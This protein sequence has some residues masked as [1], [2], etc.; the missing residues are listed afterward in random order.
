VAVQSYLKAAGRPLWTARQ[1]SD[2][3]KT[4]GTPQG[5]DPTQRIGPLPDIRAALTAVGSD[6]PGPGAARRVGP[7]GWPIHRAYG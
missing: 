1:L 4:T 3:L 2:L 6:E 5:G 7:S